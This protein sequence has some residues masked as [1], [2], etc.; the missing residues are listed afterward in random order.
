MRS[1]CERT[2]NIAPWVAGEPANDRS[3]LAAQLTT[4]L[5]GYD[6]DD[7]DTSWARSAETSQPGESPMRRFALE[8]KMLMRLSSCACV[9]SLH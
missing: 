7:D 2:T 1:F 3:A 9:R 5:Q 6:W 8:D 4:E